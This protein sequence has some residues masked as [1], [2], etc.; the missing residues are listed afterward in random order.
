MTKQILIMVLDA[1]F[2]H[3]KAAEAVEAAI[4][5]LYGDQCRVN[6]VNP[7]HSDDIPTLIRNIE[8]DYDSVV[9][10]DPDLFMLAY[11]ATDAPVVARLLHDVTTAVLDQT[12]TDLFRTY[13]PDLIVMTY[14]AFAKAIMW[15]SQKLQQPIPINVVVTDLT[16]V[17]SLWFNKKVDLTFVPTEQVYQQALDH[18]LSGKKVFVSGLPVQPAIARETRDKAT[19][20]KSLGWEV[21]LTTGLIVGSVRTGQTAAV[22]QLLDRSGLGLQLA[23]VAGGDLETEQKLRA[24]EWKGVTH[25]YGMV[26]N[27][28]EMMHAADFI[29]CKAGGLIVSEA[30]ACGLPLILYEALPGQEIGNLQYVVENS[31]GAWSPGAIGALTTAYAWLSGD[32]TELDKVRAAARRIGKPRAAYDIAEQVFNQIR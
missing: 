9:T 3:R 15:V 6:V 27:L 32:Q 19:I 20:R 17:H 14:P 13:Q 10:D 4:N 24:T 26:K 25:V 1:G 29:V 16:E 7:L 22:T 28:P 11:A 23:A 18:G 12:I 2:G 30:L 31:A 8:Q 21:D 5:E